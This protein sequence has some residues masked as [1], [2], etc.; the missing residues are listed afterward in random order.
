MSK[1][2]EITDIILE[3]LRKGEKLTVNE[4]VKKIPL[5]DRAILNFMKEC[6]FIE[7]EK[8]EVRITEFGFDLLKVE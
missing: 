5:T 3:Q 4:L 2:G 1:I 6:G 7:L 8:G